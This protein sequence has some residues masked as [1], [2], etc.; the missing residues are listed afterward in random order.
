M[1]KGCIFLEIKEIDY[2]NFGKCVLLTNGIIGV[3]VTIDFGPRVIEFGFCDKENLFYQDTKRTCKI[4]PDSGVN[5]EQTFYYYGGHRLWLSTE[6]PAKAVLPDN[7]PVVY[8][9]LPESVRFS[10]PRQKGSNFQ[11][12]FEIFMGEDT[13]DIM[14]VHT[15]KNTAKEAQ[16]CGLWPITMLKGEGVVILPQNSDTSDH[17]RPNRAVV[18][19]P[20]TEIHDERLFIGNRFLTICKTSEDKAPLKIGCNNILGWA[21]FV[22]P[23]YTFIKRYVHDVQAVYPDFGSSCEVDCQKDFVEIQSMSPMYRVEPGQEIK[24]VENLSLYQT[25]NCVNPNNE[26]DIQRYIS[27]LK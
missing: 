8:S 9:I 19:W 6:R 18:L 2:K 1:L 24:H 23:H 26:E 14:V 11:T 13:S 7:A 27:N 15:A 5:S 21:A 20:G 10:A 25:P 3:V 16:P 4:E 22:A 12:G 17:C